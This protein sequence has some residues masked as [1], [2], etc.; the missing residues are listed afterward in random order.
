MEPHEVHAASILMNLCICI[1]ISTIMP[2]VHVLNYTL[3]VLQGITILL[4]MTF[5]Y[6]LCALKAISYI[7]VIYELLFLFG[8]FKWFTFCV[9]SVPL[10]SLYL[11]DMTYI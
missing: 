11:Y 2:F 10:G 7:Y 1:G 8:G 9:L 5:T 3:F 4:C 6:T